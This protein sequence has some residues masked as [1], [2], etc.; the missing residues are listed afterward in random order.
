MRPALGRK[1]DCH[2]AA[3]GEAVALGEDANAEVQKQ[4]EERHDALEVEREGVV[5]RRVPELLERDAPA[6]VQSMAEMFE[7]GHRMIPKRARRR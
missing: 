7:C 4:R 6:T 3:G 5:P 2:C 1:A